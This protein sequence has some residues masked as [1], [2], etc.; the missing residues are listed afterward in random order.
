MEGFHG[1]SV[2]VYVK[3]PSAPKGTESLK[4][5]VW[6]RVVI[7]NYGPLDPVQHTGTIHNV[8]ATWTGKDE[9]ESFAIACMGARK[10]L[11]YFCPNF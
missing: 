3:N 2:A 10:F 5:N 4:L 11:P 9:F 8:H 1:N 6:K 7:D